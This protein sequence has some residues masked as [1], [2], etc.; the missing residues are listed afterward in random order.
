MANLSEK[1]QERLD[2]WRQ[3]KLAVRA[4]EKVTGTAVSRRNGKNDYGDA[5]TREEW[6][7]EARKS[8]TRK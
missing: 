8:Q 7:E 4:A 5:M 1:M 6:E 3:N 2:K